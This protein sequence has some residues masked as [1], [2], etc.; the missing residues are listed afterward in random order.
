MTSLRLPILSLLMIGL[1][2]GPDSRAQHRPDQAITYRNFDFVRAVTSSMTYVYFATNGGI[3]RYDKMQQKWNLPLTG[4][5]GM[6]RETINQIW[7]DRFDQTLVIGTDFS[8]YEYDDFFYRW[9]PIS[10]LPSLDSDCRHLR[11]P[12]VLLPEFDANYMGEGKFADFFGRTF[13]TTDI[14]D[15]GT[16]TLWIGTWGFGPA[17]ADASSYLMSLMPYGLLQERVDVILPDDS[18]LWI[19]GLVVDDFRT[20]L[21]AFNPESNRFFRVESGLFTGLPVEDI[22]SL[23]SDSARLYVGTPSGLYLVE[24]K[25]WSVQGPVDFRHGLPEDFVLSL[26]LIDDKLFVGTTGGLGLIDLVTDSIFHVRPETFLRHLIYDIKQV[27]QT[28]WIGSS[29]GAFRYSYESDRLQQFEDTDMVLARSVL[30]VEYHAG[31]IW[32]ASDVGVVRLD[33]TNGATKSFHEPTGL[34]DHRAMAVNDRVVAVASDHGLSFIFWSKDKVRNR[35]ITADDGLASDNVL[36]LRF[37]GDYLW[38]GTD[39]GL[40]HFLWNNPFW[41]D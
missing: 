12:D 29:A 1:F 41:I 19:G 15:D 39:H 32:F 9:Y 14:V 33:L 40:T 28:I 5:E 18:V 6:P 3:I 21:T 17:T 38:V 36:A 10:E 11:A 35:K 8:L 22:Y 13:V 27:D 26:E 20:G 25:D 16:G 31:G 2:A 34:H 24:K 4:A 7:V 23:E 30:N 37:D